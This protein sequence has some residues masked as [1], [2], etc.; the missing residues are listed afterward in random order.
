MKR[1]VIIILIILLCPTGC[2][3][4]YV[5]INETYLKI[6]SE[7]EQEY[8]V[9]M[10]RREFIYLNNWEF[11]KLCNKYCLDNNVKA[12]HLWF[13]NIKICRTYVKESFCNHAGYYKVRELIYHELLHCLN[14]CYVIGSKQRQMISKYFVST[15][16]SEDH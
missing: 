1:T 6:V 4:R 12:V 15:G 11:D 16:F 5:T 9:K 14:R 7:I 2:V 13:L 8:D 3:F 10:I